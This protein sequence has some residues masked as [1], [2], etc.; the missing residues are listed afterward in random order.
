MMRDRYTYFGKRGL[1]LSTYAA[2][3]GEGLMKKQVR[4]GGG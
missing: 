3:G 1:P 4:E 2:E